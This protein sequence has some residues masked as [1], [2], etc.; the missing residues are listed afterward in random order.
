MS[1]DG[2]L[3]VKVYF[4][5]T[6]FKPNAAKHSLAEYEEALA[7]VRDR[8]TV[9]GAPNVMPFQWFK[10][11][12]HAAYLVRQHF[13]CNLLERWSTPPFLT[14][15]E[16]RWLAFQLLQALKQCHDAGICHGDVNV[17]ELRAS[18]RRLA[19][20]RRCAAGCLADRWTA[21]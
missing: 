16:K 13:Y 7:L 20:R 11:T 2:A 3:V 18:R 1:D 6:Y 10:E 17:R 8:L 4:K 5:P 21:D 19:N 12:E 15:I 9:N 14:P